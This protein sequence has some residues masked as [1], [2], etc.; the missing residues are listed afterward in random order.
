[1]KGKEKMEIT[2][3]Q[4]MK[5]IRERFDHMDQV[6]LVKEILKAEA[7]VDGLVEAFS[8]AD[9]EICCLCIRLN[10][11]HKNCTSCDDHGKIL[12]VIAN[13]NKA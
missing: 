11:R 2:T 10:P 7:K 9:E 1:L 3:E 8:D 12:E 5:A 6:L 13:A 4:A